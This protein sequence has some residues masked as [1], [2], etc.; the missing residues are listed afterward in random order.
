MNFNIFTNQNNHLPPRQSRTLLYTSSPKARG[1]SEKPIKTIPNS[2]KFLNPIQSN[3]VTPIQPPTGDSSPPSR[4][5]SSLII[6]EISREDFER[7]KN[8]SHL[9]HKRGN[10]ADDNVSLFGKAL[11]KATTSTQTPHHRTSGSVPRAKEIVY[12]NEYFTYKKKVVMSSNNQPNTTSTK[13]IKEDSE[14]TTVKE[15]IYKKPD[16]SLS[17]SNQPNF[18]STPRMPFADLTHSNSGLG[19]QKQGS[20]SN[21]SAAR[22]LSTQNRT[23]RKNISQEH[24]LA[25]TENR[26]NEIGI[27]AFNLVTGEITISQVIIN[28]EVGSYYDSRRFLITILMFIQVRE[29]FYAVCS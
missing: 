4:K 13:E 18:F 21:R 17:N 25:I 16:S 22:L 2:L 3:I 24:I 8:Y 29:L 9:Y 14:G 1:N 15:I 26:A 28:L 6:K 20:K 11:V 27:A 10:S 5:E 7:E 19:L 23:P 12:Q